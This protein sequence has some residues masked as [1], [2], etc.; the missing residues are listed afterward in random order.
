MD[1]FEN[2]MK[3]VAR[4]EAAERGPFT[5]FALVQRADLDKWD[6]VVAAPWIGEERRYIFDALASRVKAEVGMPGMTALARIVLLN[7]SDRFVN[8]LLEAALDEESARLRNIEVN[9]LDI[10]RAVIIEGGQWHLKDDR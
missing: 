2:N 3:E 7:P 6:L 9:G 4:K 1:S 5:L 10:R 8:E